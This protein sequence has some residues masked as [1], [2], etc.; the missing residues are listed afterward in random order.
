MYFYKLN[1]Q[2]NFCDFQI[3]NRTNNI[4]ELVTVEPVPEQFN[5]PKTK[6]LLLAETDGDEERNLRLKG[7]LLTN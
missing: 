4:F 7:N 1:V 6:E 5:D 3:L 2:R